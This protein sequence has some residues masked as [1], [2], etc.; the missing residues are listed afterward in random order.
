M[1]KETPFVIPESQ[2][3][4]VPVDVMNKTHL[5]EVKMVNSLARFLSSESTKTAIE[6]IS[7]A[8]DDW[9]SHTR[10]HFANENHLMQEYRFP[11]FSIHS[12]EHER[13]LSVLESLQQQWHQSHSIENVRQFVHQTWGPWFHQH[14]NSMDKATAEYIHQQ[15][16][17]LEEA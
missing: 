14:V 13:V 3:P 17:L 1:S 15:Q 11:A 8:I 10:E 2:I 12:S 7:A 16:L 6:H 4:I 9:V 5:E